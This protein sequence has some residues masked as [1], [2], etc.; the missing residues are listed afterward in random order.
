MVLPISARKFIIIIRAVTTSLRPEAKYSSP[1]IP[2]AWSATERCVFKRG[3]SNS[4]WKCPYR[5]P[6]KS[7]VGLFGS[8][9]SRTVE[10]FF[11]FFP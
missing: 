6:M 1:E 2:N 11:R 9:V 4:L 3:T 7:I 8:D 5:S 10:N